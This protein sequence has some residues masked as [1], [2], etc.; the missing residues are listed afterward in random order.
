MEGGAEPQ[1]HLRPQ[2]R[3][4]RRRR[5]QADRDLGPRHRDQRA[6]AEDRPADAPR[7]D[8]ARH[9]H[10]QGAHGPARYYMHTGYREGS[11]G[12]VYPSL[13]SI[14]SAELGA[15]EFPL[16]NF[17]SVGGKNGYG[18][19]FLGVRHQPLIVDD[20]SKGVENLSPLVGHAPVREAG[21]PARGAGAGLPADRP[22]QRRRRPQHDLSAGRDADAVEG[23]EGVRPGAASRPR[24]GRP[25]ATASSPRAACSPAGWSRSAF[26]SSRSSRRAGTRTRTT[27]TAS[28]SSRARSI[29]RSPR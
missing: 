16:P 12:L 13:G 24:R 5:V 25:T 23:S 26:R 17:V 15:P 3:H 9:E 11:G 20:P 4:R 6:P 22:D 27:S 18:A 2:A 19:G 28:R 1:G 8:P 14:V 21:R 29:R 7:R 10:D